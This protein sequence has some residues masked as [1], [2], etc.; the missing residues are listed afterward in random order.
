MVRVISQAEAA[1]AT[2]HEG[3]VE[4]AASMTT[5]DDG[6]CQGVLVDPTL[7]ES[8]AIGASPGGIQH[9]KAWDGDDAFCRRNTDGLVDCQACLLGAKAAFIRAAASE[10]AEF[11]KHIFDE[12]YLAAEA[13]LEKARVMA[14]HS[15]VSF[16]RY[17]LTDVF[18]AYH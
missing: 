7:S 3:A 16:Q 2:V 18:P 9:A 14:S 11:V 1:T 5:A 10:Q 8:M 12:L 13:G 4:G 17:K 15:A 6:P